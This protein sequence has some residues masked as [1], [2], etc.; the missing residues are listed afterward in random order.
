MVTSVRCQPSAADEEWYSPK[1][2]FQHSG[3]PNRVICTQKYV[4]TI[5]TLIHMTFGLSHP[6]AMVKRKVS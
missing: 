6:D 2:A 4:S 1:K 3:C 5:L